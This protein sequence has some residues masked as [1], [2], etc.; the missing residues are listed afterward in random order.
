MLMAEWSAQPDP[1]A[2]PCID[3]HTHLD[4]HD[5]HLHGQQAPHAE[6]LL[7]WAAAV[8]IPK[9]VQI[10]CD[11]ESS[12]WSVDFAHTHPQVAVGVALHPNDAAR[13][14]ERH[15]RAELE[16]AFSRIDELARDRVVHAVG[17]TG[18]D[19]YRTRDA[20]GQASQQESF[21][22]HIRLAKELNKTLVIHDRDAHDD[23]IRLVLEE[24][25]PERVVFH[26]F[27]GDAAMA[28]TCAENGWYLS[29]AGVIT[30]GSAQN[31]RDA[32]AVTPENLIL[33]ETD[34]PYLTPV[35]HR[36]KANGTF[37]MPHT[38]R[39]MAK[40]RGI[41]EEHMCTLLYDNAMSAFGTW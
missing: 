21:R 2:A 5:H 24:G 20:D 19:Y 4:V 26:C 8:N 18:L 30:Y 23:V 12:E 7:A 29:F 36:G 11:V 14:A 3:T 32:L 31:L 1:L 9:V 34:A 10:G 40:E 33:T 41:S 35:P 28:R 13:L 17:E 38:V 16:K 22:W 39:F 37:L 15:G 25:S 6:E 27:S